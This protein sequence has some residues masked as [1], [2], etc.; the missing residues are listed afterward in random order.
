MTEIQGLV[1][2]ATT[3]ADAKKREDTAKKDRIK[4]EESIIA[5]VGFKK[6]EGQESYESEDGLGD[7]KIILKQPISTKVQTDVWLALRRTLD[8]K[9]PIRKIFKAKYSL[10][11]KLARALQDADKKN[12]EANWAK[13]SEC[14]ERKP[15]KV[16]VELKMLTVTQKEAN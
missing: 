7:C 11:L 3:L 9:S 10:D 4:A 16:S 13:A 12:S 15:G 2:L 8:P 1:Q 5:L 14:I 6:A